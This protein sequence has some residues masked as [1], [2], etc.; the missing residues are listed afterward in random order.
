MKV[1]DTLNARFRAP[2]ADYYKRRIIIWKDE[3][4]EFAD[5]VAELQLD[6]A[7]ILTMR[8]DVPPAPRPPADGQPSG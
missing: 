3:A 2:L 1:K 5:T 6:N 8:R 7:R 4:G